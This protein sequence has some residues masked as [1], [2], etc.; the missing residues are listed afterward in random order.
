MT[1]LT[2][3]AP[4]GIWVL[5]ICK[6]LLSESLI[7]DQVESSEY[8]SCTRQITSPKQYVLLR[9]QWKCSF[10]CSIFSG[11]KTLHQ[12]LI[13]PTWMLLYLLWM[14]TQNQC[15]YVTVCVCAG[16]VSRAGRDSCLGIGPRADSRS[17]TQSVSSPFTLMTCSV[18]ISITV[19]LNS[20]ISLVKRCS[21]IFCNAF[22]TVV[23]AVMQIMLILMCLLEHVCT[24]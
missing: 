21:V 10:K 24:V 11:I 22:L 19:M 17:G 5:S 8:Y 12:L 6:T 2:H 14:L 13:I 20:R 1:R 16:S 3:H 15:M 7:P 18:V 9:K 4:C 23:L